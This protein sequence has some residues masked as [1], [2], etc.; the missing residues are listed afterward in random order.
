MS[1]KIRVIFVEPL[2]KPKLITIDHTL[3]TLQKLVGGYI[4]AEYP[5]D[6]EVALICND[7]GKI[8]DSLPNRRL[9]ECED[10]IFGNFLITGLTEDSFGS[11]SSD[12]AEKY[13]A[14]F[15]YPEIFIRIGEII[16]GKN[17]S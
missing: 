1:E 9:E 14:R 10:V 8:N 7:E 5:F 4:A 15:E 13:M 6:D 16:N 12:L 3:E 11:L 2:E 17:K